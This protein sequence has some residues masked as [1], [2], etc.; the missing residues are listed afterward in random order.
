MQWTFNSEKNHL[1][2]YFSYI[3]VR[4][5]DCS[6]EHDMQL[7]W[8]KGCNLIRSRHLLTPKAGV[9][10]E[11]EKHYFVFQTIMTRI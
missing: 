7:V 5:L 4:I 10:F 1:F 2:L 11:E 8:I 3:M 6:T 9:K